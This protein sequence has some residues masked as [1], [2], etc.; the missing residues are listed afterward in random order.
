MNTDADELRI[1]LLFCVLEM[2]KGNSFRLILNKLLQENDILKQPDD[3]TPTPPQADPDDSKLIA[4]DVIMNLFLQKLTDDLNNPKNKFS[5]EVISKYTNLITGLS[6][7]K[8]TKNE[9]AQALRINIK[10]T[11]GGT[12]W[13]FRL[14]TIKAYN[15]P[16][17]HKFKTN[18]HTPKKRHLRKRNTARA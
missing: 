8:D 11:G 16:T 18:Q 12:R 15:R 3:T 17:K 4:N 13:N 7:P 6:T 1:T 9:I 14:R 10:K 2:F 5:E